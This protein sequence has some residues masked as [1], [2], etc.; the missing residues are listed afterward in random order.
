MSADTLI[1]DLATRARKAARTL[2]TAS[3]TDRKPIELIAQAIEK[4]SSEILA[5]NALDLAQYREEK[6]HPQMQDRLLLTDERIGRDCIGARQV[7]ALPDPL[8][9]TLREPTLPNGLQLRQISVP[10]GVVG[11]V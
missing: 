3:S 9:Q 10:F 11:M 4:R 1:A 5:A 8:G 7:A 6:M 2:V